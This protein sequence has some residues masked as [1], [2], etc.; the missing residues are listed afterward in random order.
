M[1]QYECRRFR[2]E[3]G[4][5]DRWEAA[6]PLDRDS[7]EQL[8]SRLRTMIADVSAHRPDP[9]DGSGWLTIDAVLAGLHGALVALGEVGREP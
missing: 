9:S 5:C 6:D 8:A 7:L 4:V 3:D 2:A 1:E